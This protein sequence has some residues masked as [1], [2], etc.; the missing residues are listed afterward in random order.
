MVLWIAAELWV[1]F[2]FHSK[3][4]NLSIYIHIPFCSSKCGYC[5]FYSSSD[6][7]DELKRKIIEK[8]CAD[9]KMFPQKGFSVSSVFI[10]GG[11]P[12]SLPLNLLENIF[13]TIN[14]S[15]SFNK[16]F[17]WTIEANPELISREFLDLCSG[18]R[19]NRLSLGI[20]SF[21]KQHL[22]YLNRQ[23]EKKD[24]IDALDTVKQFWPGDL[25]L[26]VINGLPSQSWGEARRDLETAVTINPDHISLYSLTIEQGTAL[27]EQIKMGKVKSPENDF[28]SLLLNNSKDLLEQHGYVNYEISNYYKKEKNDKRCVH[29]LGYWNMN[30][31]A[32][33]GPSAVGTLPSANGNT[34]IQRIHEPR[35]MFKF[36]NNEKVIEILSPSDLLKEQIMMSLR[37]KDGINKNLFSH[38]FA[39]IPEQIIPETG[40]KWKDLLIISDSFYALTWQGRLLLDSF[41]EDAFF[42]I[43]E[44][45]IKL[46]N[47]P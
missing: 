19:V 40:K 2:F 6:A 28:A 3:M 18:N 36:L 47:Y 27:Y 7:S 42:E 15:F 17:E 26:D 35:D 4:N 44:K 34:D 12:N 25:S 39:V 11:T 46:Y 14:T 10:G 20:Q 9:I 32:G 41:L 38:R 29:N 13:H 33:F 21:Q 22:L 37:L 23:A 31:Y 45:S 30:P 43:D 5:D 16:V 1:R 24:V 8:I